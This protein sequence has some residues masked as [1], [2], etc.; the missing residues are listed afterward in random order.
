M[1]VTWTFPT[2]TEDCYILYTL[3]ILHPAAFCC[4]CRKLHHFSIWP[5]L[6][7]AFPSEHVCWG[8]ELSLVGPT[9]FPKSSAQKQV[10]CC[11]AV[12]TAA[13]LQMS[14]DLLS[15]YLPSQNQ[16]SIAAQCVYLSGTTSARHKCAVWTPQTHSHVFCFSKAHIQRGGFKSLSLVSLTTKLENNLCLC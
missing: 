9:P 1:H 6:S 4:R 15:M 5:Q 10:L 13:S 3:H 7:S 14:H 8:S 12:S 11:W 16:L 2:L